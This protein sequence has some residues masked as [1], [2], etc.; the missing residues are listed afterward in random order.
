VALL[1]CLLRT[2]LSALGDKAE[3]EAASCI[4]AAQDCRYTG[5]ADVQRRLHQL[6]ASGLK[7]TQNKQEHAHSV[8]AVWLGALGVSTE[9]CKLLKGKVSTL[10]S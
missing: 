3:R 10:A 7:E 1:L 5:V 9:A 2:L 8:S 4:Q 6:T